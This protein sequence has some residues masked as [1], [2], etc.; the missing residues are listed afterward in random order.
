VIEGAAQLGR[1]AGEHV[2]HPGE[3]GSL[4]PGHEARPRERGV[5]REGAARVGVAAELRGGDVQDQGPELGTGVARDRPLHV[6]EVARAHRAE[7]AAEP[8]L[9]LQ[10]GDGGEGVVALFAEGIEVAARSERAAAALHDDLEA[11]LGEEAPEEHAPP[12]AAPVR[13]SHEQ[14]GD[15]SSPAP[16]RHVAVGEQDDAVGHGDLE[17]CLDDDIVGLRGGELEEAPHEPAR[18]GHRRTLVPLGSPVK[19]KGRARPRPVHATGA[20]LRRAARRAGAPA[21]PGPRRIAWRGLPGSAA[22]RASGGAGTPRRPGGTASGRG[23]R[24]A[25][26]SSP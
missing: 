11:A 7:R 25:R 5:E 12:A 19:P 4:L 21:R 2:L 1:H 18:D 9:L 10:P 13:R 20:R 17:V 23:P 6:A 24:R 15:F 14:R 26:T 3:R 22:P 8:G 16:A